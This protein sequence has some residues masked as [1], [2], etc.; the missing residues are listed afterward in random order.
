M[1]LTVFLGPYISG[2]A[3]I[4]LVVLLISRRAARNLKIEGA[5]AV[6][7][8]LLALLW[9]AHLFKQVH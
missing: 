3:G 6:G 2:L 5:I 1:L 8:S 4:L 7:I 9:A